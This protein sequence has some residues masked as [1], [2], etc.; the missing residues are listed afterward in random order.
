MFNYLLYFWIILLYFVEFLI[1]LL[2]PFFLTQELNPLSEKAS[3][4]G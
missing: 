4:F 3:T 2:N 1:I